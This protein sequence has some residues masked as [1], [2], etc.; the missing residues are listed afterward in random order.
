MSKEH[1][2][3]PRPK[4]PAARRRGAAS[5][6]RAHPVFGLWPVRLADEL[7]AAMIDEDIRKVDAWTARHRLVE[8]AFA[9]ELGGR[10][11]RKTQYHEVGGFYQW[12]LN[13]Y[14]D[15]RFSGNIAIPGGG[16]KDIARLADCN[17]TAPGVQACEGNDVALTGEARFRARF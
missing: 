9:P 14:F 4:G 1:A 13:P 15:I 16:Y 5:G 7:R 6:G 12:T 8:V 3:L 2:P 11:I 10:G 17:L